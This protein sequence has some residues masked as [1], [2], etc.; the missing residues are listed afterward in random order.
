MLAVVE[1]RL[2][3]IE[4]LPKS[5][6]GAEIGVYAGDFSEMLLRRAAPRT[7]HLIDPWVS[8]PGDAYRHALYGANQLD[9]AGMDN[10]YRRVLQ[11]F[12]KGIEEAS[13]IV[14]RQRSVEALSQFAD[15]HLDWIYIDG[16]HTLHAVLSDLHLAR[17]KVKPGG[18]IAGD[19]YG[20]GGWWGDGV[21]AALHQFLAECDAKIVIHSVIGSQ[22]LLRR[23]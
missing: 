20:L 21:I 13:V 1:P 17:R 23:L 7:L 5:A 10:L 14:H 19:D 12:R 9:Q 8:Q 4:H 22:F 18:F 11:R 2:T 15:G 6:V 3:L 16:D